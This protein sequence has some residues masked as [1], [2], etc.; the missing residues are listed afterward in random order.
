[1]YE[2]KK[3]FAFDAA[4]RLLHHKGLCNNLHGHTYK[5]EVV[6]MGDTL[7][8]PDNILIDFQELKESIK[9]WIDRS[10]DHAVIL[11]CEDPLAKQIS[12]FT[13]RVFLM[14]ADPTCEGMSRF[15]YEHFKDDSLFK[16]LTLLFVVHETPTSAATFYP[17]KIEVSTE[18]RET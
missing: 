3:T 11:N 5:V 10:W 4:H 9:S 12:D 8:F 15:L 13:D 2:L 7:R 1:M 16:D 14:D 17:T 6:I 18:V